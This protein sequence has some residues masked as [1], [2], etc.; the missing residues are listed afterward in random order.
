MV[1]IGG[2]VAVRGL[3][4]VTFERHEGYFGPAFAPDGREVWFFQRNSSGW[5]AGPGWEHFTPPARVF[6]QSDRLA[7]CRL[8]LASGRIETV[9]AWERTPLQ[10]RWLANY[11]GRV[12]NILGTRIRTLRDGSVDYTARISIPVVPRSEIWSVTGSWSRTGAS[13]Q[14]WQQRDASLAG[15]SEP[16]VAGD[17]EVMTLPGEESFPAAIVVLDHRDRTVRTVVRNSAFDRLYPTGPDLEKLLETS[18][19]QEVDRTADMKRTHEELVRTYRE[20]GMRE[21]DALLAAG[22]EMAR[23]GWWPT[24]RSIVAHEVARL[25]DGVREFVIDPME[26]TV[27]LFPDLERALAHPGEAVEKSGRYVRHR[28]YRT[29]EL[30]N[31]FF[32]S[33]PQRF[34]ISLQGKRWLVEIIP[35]RPPW[36]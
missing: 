6:M 10:G 26:I 8:D 32:Q 5:A 22:R 4:L 35:E 9:L 19:K 15:L 34:G 3:G 28:D 31:E 29:S 20:N 7:L 30:L 16:V 25:P 2:T 12:L 23:L 18:R 1:A 17:L 24:P 11:R 13:P 21:G 33:D 36:R 27:G 14:P